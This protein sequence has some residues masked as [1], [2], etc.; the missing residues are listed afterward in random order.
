MFSGSGNTGDKWHYCPMS[1]YLENRN[2]WPLTGNKNYITYISASMHNS[3]EITTVIPMF[4]G[5][6]YTIR[7]LRR[8]PDVWICEKAEM[9]A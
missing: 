9:A 2:W 5:S 8:L 1:G 6:D 3:N 4:W 7:L